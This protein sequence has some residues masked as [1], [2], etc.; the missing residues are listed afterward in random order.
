MPAFQ[1][2][3]MPDA[4]LKFAQNTPMEPIEPLGPEEL[5]KAESET[6]LHHPKTQQEV[7]LVDTVNAGDHRNC[8]KISKK[9]KYK[10]AFFVTRILLI[11]MGKQII[12]K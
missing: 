8:F 10:P 6:P 9:S 7:M 12:R 1:Q 4:K 5:K 2:N 3:E 11:I